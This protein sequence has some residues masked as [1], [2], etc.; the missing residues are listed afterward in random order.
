[1]QQVI[2]FYTAGIPTFGYVFLNYLLLSKKMSTIVHEMF[3]YEHMIFSPTG[4]T[5]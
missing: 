1:M 3:L 2:S 5:T 4:F